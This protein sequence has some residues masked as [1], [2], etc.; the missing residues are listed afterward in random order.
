MASVLLINPPILKKDL[1]KGGA[2]VA[3]TKVEP[4]GIAYVAAVLEEAGHRAR[5]IDGIAEESSIEAISR[6]AQHFD[7]VGTSACTAFA[8]RAYDAAK[9]IKEATGVEVIFGGPHATAIP[10]EV[11]SQEFIDYAVVG[12]GEYTIS[13]LATALERKKPISKVKGL[14]Y[15][16]AGTTVF[17]GERPFLKNIDQIPMPARHLLPMHLY[18][19]SEARSRRLPS[20]SLITSRGCPFNCT[21]CDKHIFGR[22]FRAHS[23]ERVMQ[24]MELLVGKYKARDIGI[25]DD[26]FTVDK[27]R[28]L[29]ICEMMKQRNWDLT[30]SCEARVDCID[31]PVLRALKSAGCEYIAYGVESGSQRI[32]DSIRKGFSKSK[33]RE[34]F[35]V[36]QNVGIGIRGYF[37][38]GLPGETKHDIEQTISFAKELN[39]TI[40]TFTF[41]TPWPGTDAYKQVVKSHELSKQS[42]WLEGVV[43]DFNFLEDPIYVPKRITKKGLVELHKKAYMS[44][45]L[46][47]G[48]MMQRVLSIRHVE[49]IKMMAK[50][51]LAIVKS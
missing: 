8:K 2:A 9:A 32:L 6:E 13:E 18:T 38:V 46:R 10:S 48:Y 51:F 7:F 39:P 44:F 31:E 36:T 21:F 28:V 47:P 1:Y 12:E 41:F 14:Y 43:P 45:Y 27:K 19:G 49:D 26:N 29:K 30:F 22:S 25:W 34:T 50:G 33:V 3:Q 42:Y 40:A 35:K 11:I 15:K 5:I 20:R 37:I 17:T 16:K 23:P 24:E 4:L